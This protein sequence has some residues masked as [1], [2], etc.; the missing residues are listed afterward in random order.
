M[1]KYGPD[2][3]VAESTETRRRRVLGGSNGGA[4]GQATDEPQDRHAHHGLQT[5]ARPPRHRR[6][7]LDSGDSIAPPSSCASLLAAMPVLLILTQRGVGCRPCNKPP[8]PS[9]HAPSCSAI[10]RGRRPDL[11]RRPLA[12]LARA[13]GRRAQHLGG[14]GRRHGRGPR[15]HRRPQARHPL[16]RLGARRHARALHAGRGRHRGLAHLRRRRSTSGAGARPDAARRACRRS[17]EQLEP[18]PSRHRSPSPQRP[19]QV[20][21]RHL[22]RRHRQRRARAAVREPRRALAASSLDRQLVPRLAT[23]TRAKEGGRIALPHRGR[24]A[25]ADRRGR[26]RGRPDHLHHRLHAR[27]RHALQ[28]LLDRP[29]QGGAVRHRL[30]PPARSGVLAE[31]PKA[32]IGRVLAHPRRT[33][34]RRPAPST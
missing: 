14:A 1:R 20:L 23:K 19:R 30:A 13:Q 32:D 28:R 25:R 17:I 15:H 2:L 24:Q 16:P 31:H 8:N 5:L 27:R 6:V 21:A 10:R 18:R 9:F 26:A 22:S 29:R 7:A 4:G 12:V 3:I 11:A 33:W 34:S